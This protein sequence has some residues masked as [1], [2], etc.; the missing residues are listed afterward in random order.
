ENS[1]LS[2]VRWNDEGSPAVVIANL[3]DRSFPEYE[4]SHFPS[5]G[6]WKDSLNGSTAEAKDGKLTIE[7]LP[8]SAQV[9]TR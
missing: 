7:L 2:Y 4:I 6:L 8:F 3:G 5:D 1:I 9:F